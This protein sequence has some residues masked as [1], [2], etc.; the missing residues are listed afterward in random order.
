MIRITVQEYEVNDPDKGNY[1]YLRGE[2]AD[3]GYVGWSNF[4]V[5]E[6]DLRRFS[7][8]LKGFAKD[9]RGTPELK[10]GWENEVYFRVQ[11]EKWKST[12]AL[13]VNGEIATPAHPKV[14]LNAPCSHRFVFGFPLEPVQLDSF[15]ANLVGLIDGA[16][17]EI[18]LESGKE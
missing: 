12:G 8:E 14:N 5:A 11:F 3:E 7:E 10:T 16:R 18:I 2:I 1:Y 6:R 15:I 9:F 13:W 4:V 17:K